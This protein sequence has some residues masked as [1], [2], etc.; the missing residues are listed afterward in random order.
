MDANGCDVIGENLG[1]EWSRA[2]ARQGHVLPLG[3]CIEYSLEQGGAE[4][5]SAHCTL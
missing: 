2:V 5:P 3:A 4:L 1:S